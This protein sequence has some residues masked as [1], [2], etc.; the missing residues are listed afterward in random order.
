[1][2]PEGI[3]STDEI[4]LSSELEDGRW[5]VTATL[6]TTTIMTETDVASVETLPWLVASL[7]QI[8]ETAWAAI[9]TQLSEETE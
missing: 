5:L 1:M 8:L 2:L 7:P 3:D 4:E 9:E 6:G